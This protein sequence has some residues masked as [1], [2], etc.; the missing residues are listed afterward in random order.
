MERVLEYSQLE[1]EEHHQTPANVAKS[2][3][4][5]G[6]IEFK[7]VF[8]R[9]SVGSEPVLRGLSFSIRPKEKV[10]VVGRTGAG[11]SSLISSLFRL[12]VIEGEIVIDSVNTSTVQLA[13]LRSRISIIPQ[14]PTLFSGT[15]RRQVTS[16]I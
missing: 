6:R 15:L 13:T 11:K 9:Y 4:N 5:E 1:P 12:A 14:D 7:N 8:Y 10:S 2:W 3:P 16:S